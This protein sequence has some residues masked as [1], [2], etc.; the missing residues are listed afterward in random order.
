MQGHN[1]YRAKKRRPL[2]GYLP[3]PPHMLGFVQENTLS[4]LE[5][6]TR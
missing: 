6:N 3:F 5:N 2:T 1:Y 4:L